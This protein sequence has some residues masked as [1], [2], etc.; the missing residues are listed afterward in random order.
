MDSFDLIKHSTILQD[1]RDFG[2][3]L[4][5]LLFA[6]FIS[7]FLS[8]AMIRAGSFFQKFD[9]TSERKIHSGKISRLGGIAL[10]AGVQLTALLVFSM[11]AVM[12]FEGIITIDKWEGLAL[13]STTLFL[14]CFYDDL[15]DCRW[16]LKLCAQIAAATLSFSYGFRFES[17]LGFDL[18]LVIDLAFTIV[19][20]LIFINSFNLIDGIDGLAA[21]L[22]ICS[23]VGL[24]VSAFVG[25]IPV[26]L[27]LSLAIVGA[28]A[29]FLVYNV[30]PAR[31]FMGDAGSNFLGFILSAIA[32]LSV[33]RTSFLLSLLIPLLVIG[34]PA[35]ELIVTVVRRG[36]RSLWKG[37]GWL[38]AAMSTVQADR[39]HLHHK[40]IDAGYS[41]ATV[42]RILYTMNLGVVGLCLFL[43]SLQG[44]TQPLLLA[45]AL[46]AIILVIESIKNVAVWNT[47]R[48][49]QRGLSW[50]HSSE[51][52]SLAYIMGD[53]LIISSILYWLNATGLVFSRI[54]AVAVGTSAFLGLAA[55]GTYKLVWRT[56]DISV[57]VWLT[58]GVVAG[59]SIVWTFFNAFAPTWSTLPVTHILRFSFLTSF[60][61]ILFRGFLRGIL[62]T[63]PH[64]FQFV[65]SAGKDFPF[66][67]IGR[68]S[69]EIVSMM[70]EDELRSILGCSRTERPL[71]LGVIDET[72]SLKGRMIG[73]LRVLQP[74]EVE[75]MNQ[76]KSGVKIPRLRFHLSFETLE[77][78]PVPRTPS[79]PIVDKRE[80][81]A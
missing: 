15:L 2:K 59:T 34:I 78:I 79:R 77:D 51:L 41:Q 73:A 56:A 39:G 64:I 72:P 9:P 76:A 22:A 75:Y 70:G 66:I 17:L 81:R 4:V 21:G 55:M 7:A 8:A 18:P 62:R 46:T 48:A 6:F 53:V 5:V 24:I 58:V 23:S 45:A 65:P 61:V 57:V 37:E 43:V 12:P 25:A 3:Y 30:H 60:F 47:P 31:I 11:Q 26:D 13:A 54:E 44:A 80:A 1:L 42:A 10:F 40:L 49:I 16:W 19:W 33:S 50:K 35:F 38:R 67:V 27:M 14:I 63:N 20:F 52:V 71:C 74:R 69:A 68:R 28:C 32:L 29:G 36:L